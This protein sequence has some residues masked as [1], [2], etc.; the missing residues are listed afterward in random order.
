MPKGEPMNPRE[1][2]QQWARQR[3][4][5]ARYAPRYGSL[6]WLDMS[7]ADERKLAGLVVAAECWASTGD[8][9]ATLLGVEVRELVADE[10]FR[11]RVEHADFAKVARMVRSYASL[12]THAELQRRRGR[13]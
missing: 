9:L 1:R 4:R 7:D 12:P 6:E 2:R 8:D 3:I 10:E 11:T 13:V 5:A